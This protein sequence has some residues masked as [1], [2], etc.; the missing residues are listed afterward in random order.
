MFRLGRRNI[1]DSSSSGTAGGVSRGGAETFRLAF[2]YATSKVRPLNPKKAEAKPGS[3][4]SPAKK[5][6][7]SAKPIVS[8]KTSAKV[9]AWDTAMSRAEAKPNG[10]GL[11][12][13]WDKL[14]LKLSGNWMMK[15]ILDNLNGLM[16]YQVLAEGYITF[17]FWYLMKYHYTPDEMQKIVDDYYLGWYIDLKEKVWD[18]DIKMLPMSKETL[19][20]LSQAH[21]FA[22]ASWPIQIPLVLVSYKYVKWIFEGMLKVK[23]HKLM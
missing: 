22:T 13:A 11:R 17:V 1:I 7:N 12:G 6:T 16:I 2:R 20:N 15:Y 9:T 10:T 14:R 23:K 19:T 3:G 4:A 5:F 18:D 21:A 8:A